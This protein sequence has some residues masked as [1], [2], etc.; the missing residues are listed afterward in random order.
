MGLIQTV[1]LPSPATNDLDRSF[2]NTNWVRSAVSNFEAIAR[3]NL[4]HELYAYSLG[5][6]NGYSYERG[7]LIAPSEVRAYQEY[8]RK[9]YAGDLAAMNREWS[10]NYTAFEAIAIPAFD[11]LKGLNDIPQ[12]HLWMAFCEKEYTD[13]NN[14]A[15]LT[16]N[17]I[18]PRA[19]AGAEGS[20]EGNME[21]ML[22]HCRVWGPY[23][24]RLANVLMRS[25]GPP[26]PSL[27]RGN[28]WGSYV[29]ERP[30]MGQNYWDQIL[31]GG[32]NSSFYWYGPG[33]FSADMS[34]A[35][36]VEQ[37]HIP[38]IRE[39]MAGVGPLL[40]RS[41]VAHM[42][43]GLFYS[44]PSLH[45]QTIDVRFGTPG[46]ACNGLL[47]YCENT[48]VSAY[49]YSERQ[50]RAGKLDKDGVRILFLPQALCM[51]DDTAQALKAWVARGGTLVADQQTGLRTERGAARANGALDEL[52]GI[53]Q[54]P[55][56]APAT[57]NIAASLLGVAVQWPG[58]IVDA[59]VATTNASALLLDG[60]IPVLVSRAVGKGQA[61]FFNLSLGKILNNHGDDSAT[62]GF[63]TALLD[64]AGVFTGLRPPRG[65]LLTRFQGEGYELLSCRIGPEGKTGE[66]VELGRT[67]YVYDTRQGKCLGAVD[68]VT[69]SQCSGRNNL[70]ALLPRQA[71][72]VDVTVP[73]S[74]AAG[75]IVEV[76]LAPRAAADRCTPARLYRVRVMAP[77]GKEIECLREFAEGREAVVRVRIP[78]ALNQPAGAYAAEATDLLTGI[79]QTRPLTVV[80]GMA[81]VGK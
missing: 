21:D 50:I 27:L 36:F 60:R 10:T 19:R 26:G 35:D 3:Q 68:R 71:S 18:D 65:Y 46:S 9:I 58:V 7:A 48:G 28:W 25:F 17:R 72:E 51:G 63:V 64:K 54:D 12:K 62:R 81:A 23:P 34:Y 31:S 38:V 55:L 61:V 67:N 79:K 80:A 13:L 76:G 33:L 74:A 32:V 42:G 70:F 43:V 73:N 2:C 8:L 49:F 44:K 59:R 52:F 57:T 40:N 16:I 78:L 14:L 1:R 56:G 22:E 24:D 20:G 11:K 41:P 4:P 6:E 29:Q 77:E 47:T 45:A 5:D 53:Q 69:P 37:G 39:V 66:T 75:T 15:A 30:A